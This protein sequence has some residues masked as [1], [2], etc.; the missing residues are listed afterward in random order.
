MIKKG[1][2]VKLYDTVQIS[3]RSVEQFVGTVA[4][5]FIGTNSQPLRVSIVATHSGRITRNHGFYLPQKMRDG[6]QTL[7][8]EYGKPILLHHND[9]ND[10][11]GRVVTSRYVDT[12]GVFQRDKAQDFIIKRICDSKTPFLVMLD[13]YD[14]LSETDL[15]ADPLFPGLGHIVIDVDISDPD[16]IKKILDKR[17]LTVSI[18]ATT[19]KAICSVCKTDWVEEGRCEHTPG[20]EYEE[21]LCVIIAGN[22]FY[23]EVSFVNAP[24]DPLARIVAVGVSD[25]LH[26]SVMG[27]EVADS[28]EV[29][30]SFSFQ[31]T[32][33]TGGKVM[34]KIKEAWEKVLVAASNE[35]TDKEKRIE[36]FKNFLEKF[37]DAEKNPYKEEA[38]VEIAKLEVKDD[39]SSKSKSIPTDLP[40]AKDLLPVIDGLTGEQLVEADKH[41]ED[42]VQLGY[43][44]SLLDE[45]FEDAKLTPEKRK[46]LKKGTFC[47]PN[48]RKYPVPDCSHARVAM[49]Y[50]KKHNEASSVIAC[51]RRK[52]KALGCPFNGKD[53]FEA[54]IDEIL[55]DLKQREDENKNV[56]N[57]NNQSQSKNET[58]DDD[59]CQ[60]CTDYKEQLKALRQELKDSYNESSDDEKAYV[61][62]LQN[63]R[64]ALA[65]TLVR[66]DI[67]SNKE[68]KDFE[69]DVQST[70]TLKIED[71]LSRAK[72]I[73]ESLDLEAVI[74]K[75]NDG[76][77]REPTEN[78]E[79][80][81]KNDDTI[82]D[83]LKDKQETNEEKLSRIRDNYET[84]YNVDPDSADAYLLNLRNEGIIPNDFDVT[85]QNKEESN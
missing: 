37:K 56:S 71:L 67:V 55:A 30:A 51:I 9:H 74:G 20:K 38:E 35:E 57:T 59:I 23:D 26:D 24:A 41:Y 49:A 81:T 11:I 19:D 8:A 68:I 83:P 12:S 70:A 42:T 22:L 60:T 4:D 80:L 54:E 50:A 39:K 40:L 78:I 28:F 75:L 62:T 43:S 33:A 27:A 14:Q 65:D 79:D 15:L 21:K 61:E 58:E 45:D 17:Y 72:T 84:F 63:I 46:S 64:L 3:P 10:P 16:A 85:K 13:L 82:I 76:M 29:N 69:K 66:L 6:A 48:E 25:G 32:V 77:S 52:A 36:A 18:G 53:G 1:K 34:D 7:V 31:D 5:N 47:K 44:L 73:R 2:F